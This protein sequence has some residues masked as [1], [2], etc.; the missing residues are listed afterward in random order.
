VVN[1]MTFG[2]SCGMISGSLERQVEPNGVSA[3]D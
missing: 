2:A 1:G 3:G